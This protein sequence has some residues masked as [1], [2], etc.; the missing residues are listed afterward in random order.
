VPTVSVEPDGITVE[1]RPGEGIL[2]ALN[3]SGYGYRVGCRRGGC[4]ICKVD[5]LAGAVEYPVTVAETVLPARD[6]AQACAL[7]C[8]AIPVQDVVIRLRDD[9]LRCTSP[10]LAAVFRVRRAENTATEGQD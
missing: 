4:G 1:T 10:L 9:R 2:A 3:R 8:R 6:R 7:S 5:V